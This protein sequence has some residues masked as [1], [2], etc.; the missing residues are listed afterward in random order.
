MLGFLRWLAHPGRIAPVAYLV[1]WAVGTGLLMSPAASETGRPTGFWEAGFTAMSALCITGLAVVDTAGHWSTFGE[2]TILGLI[3]VGGLGIMTLGSLVVFSVSRRR[4]SLA[5]LDAAL[6]E[7]RARTRQGLR[8]IPIRIISLSLAFELVFALVL[9]LRLR[10]YLPDWGTAAYHGVFHAVSAFNNAGFALQ[11]DSLVRFNADP[12]IMVPISLAVVLGGL[13]FPV[14]LE[15]GRRMLGHGSAFWSVHLRLTLWGTLVLLVLGFLTFV[16]F[17][18]NNPA[19]L[20][21]QGVDGKV[22]GALGGA[23]FPRT[24]GFNSIDYALASDQTIAINFG[25]MLIG[26]GSA[27]TAGGLK[28]TTIAVLL[29]AVSTEVRGHEKTVF[30]SRKISS[31]VTRQA[32]AVTVLGTLAVFAGI[33]GVSLLGGAPLRESTFEVISAFGTVGLSMN[34]TPTL[35]PAAWAVL[36]GLMYVG[37]VGPV[38]V[39]AAL[40]M[41]TRHRHYELPREDPL[42]G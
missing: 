3:Q 28:V 15:L 31:A 10:A 35:P 22:L 4:A 34:L 26:G 29:L 37:R 41:S 2:L 7:T 14:Y 21:G 23:V 6:V 40:A 5:Q 36:M 17:E 42:V 12:F 16:A 20:G 1:G 19:T 32:L 24:A 8:R 18:W 27:G 39:A 25:L 30:G 11:P 9:T 33:L 13:G 38:S